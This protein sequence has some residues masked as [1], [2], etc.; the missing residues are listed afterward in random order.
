MGHPLPS[1][2]QKRLA[3]LRLYHVL[4]TAPEEAFD[5]IALVAAEVAGV[6]TAIVSLIDER[7]QW[8]KAKIGAEVN[9]VPRE[10]TFCTHTI[11]GTEVM[12]VEDATADPRFAANP[13]VTKAQGVRF[14]AGAPILDDEGNA[15]GSVCVVDSRPRQLGAPKQEVLMALA[16]TT[17]VLLEQRRLSHLLAE[18]LTEVKTVQG[19]LPICA[20]CK[21][22]RTS[23]D[24]WERIE[25]YFSTR[26][27]ALF[28]HGMCPVCMQ[29]QYPE[30]YAS[31]KAQGKI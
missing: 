25:E 9:E 13:H 6:P 10:Q 31:L 16:R 14:Y 3:A 29:R 21:S 24:Y 19:L 1:N 28:S 23:D 27:D 5:D 22:I 8:Y 18:A 30:I 20:S 26:T 17:M 15:L 11:L 4:D 2:E 12:V 7:R